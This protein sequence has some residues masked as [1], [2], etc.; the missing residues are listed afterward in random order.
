MSKIVIFVEDQSQ[1][2]SNMQ[3]M[4]IAVFRKT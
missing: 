3:K 1:E 4:H 2:E